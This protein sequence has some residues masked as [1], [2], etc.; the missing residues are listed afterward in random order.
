MH[1]DAIGEQRQSLRREL[2]L[3]LTSLRRTRPVEGAF[4]QPLRHQ[5]ETRAIKVK[6]LEPG[7]PLIGKH[8]QSPA[9]VAIRGFFIALAKL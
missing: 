9:I 6:H 3:C 5:P 8:K 2:Q 4:F 1:V 7:A